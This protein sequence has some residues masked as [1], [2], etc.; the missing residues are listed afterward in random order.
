M[1]K[2]TSIFIISFLCFGTLLIAQTESTLDDLLDAQEY[3][4]NNPNEQV[5]VIVMGKIDMTDAFNKKKERGWPVM[6]IDKL[7]WQFK[8]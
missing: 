1:I 6:I 4:A 2:R 3:A 5:N 7:K 8:D